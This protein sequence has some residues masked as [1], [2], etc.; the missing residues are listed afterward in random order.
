MQERFPFSYRVGLLAALM[1][2]AAGVDFC[3]HGRAATQ[4]KEYAFIWLAGLIGCLI[5]GAN[6]LIT[7]SISPE[8]FSLGKG[9]PDGETLKLR[10]AMYG[11]KE[12]LS[13]GVI[14]GAVCVYASRRKTTV[15]PLAFGGMLRLLWMPAGGAVLGAVLL[16]LI[17]SRFDPMGFAVKLDGMIAAGPIVQFRRVWWIHTGLYSGLLAGLLALI[18]VVL[19]LRRTAS[20]TA[21]KTEKISDF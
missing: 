5:G 13:A 20:T 3:R 14:G 16:P 15:P 19:K 21:P 18:V 9:L 4:Y 7:S 2:I 10:A 1:A 17:A 11:I 12:G 6:D 8:F